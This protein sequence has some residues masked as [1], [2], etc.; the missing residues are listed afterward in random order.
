MSSL[1]WSLLQRREAQR[2]GS[3][4]VS[5]VKHTSGC[6]SVGHLG[7][8]SRSGTS[9]IGRI[10]AL[11]SQSSQHLSDV[12]T[13]GSRVVD[14]Q[15]QNARN[16]IPGASMATPHVPRSTVASIFGRWF[17][18]LWLQGWA[19][20]RSARGQLGRPP[21]V[22]TRVLGSSEPAP[23]EPLR[24]RGAQG[25]VW[26]QPSQLDPPIVGSREPVQKILRFFLAWPSPSTRTPYQR[27]RLRGPD[28]L[29][30]YH[31]LRRLLLCAALLGLR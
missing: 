1:A 29:V 31:H 16:E 5:L 15:R 21:P 17:V 24:G 12:S 3:R 23:E 9:V 11:G 28:L 18:W 7:R 6:E 25:V 19:E 13:A 22:E 14:C 2:C 27:L 26:V 4:R 30:H 20:S 10:E 8:S